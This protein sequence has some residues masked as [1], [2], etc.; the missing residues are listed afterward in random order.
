MEKHLICSRHETKPAPEAG[1]GK[2]MREN[3]AT[4]VVYRLRMI[5]S[6]KPETKCCG[7]HW[8]KWWDHYGGRVTLEHKF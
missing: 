7:P 6:V 2:R 5:E 1:L 3:G 4:R 8:K